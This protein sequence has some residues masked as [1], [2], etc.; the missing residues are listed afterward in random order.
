MTATYQTPALKVTTDREMN[1]FIRRCVALNSG[2]YPDTVRE[3]K[4]GTVWA[5]EPNDIPGA[6]WY[7]ATDNNKTFKTA[8]GALRLLADGVAMGEVKAQ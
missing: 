5:K 7:R 1:E 3:T 4:T 8:Y 6:P 2:F